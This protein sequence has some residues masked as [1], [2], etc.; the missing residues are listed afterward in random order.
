MHFLTNPY[1]DDSIAMWQKLPQ[2][3]DTGFPKIFPKIY[4]TLFDT[5]KILHLLTP[6]TKFII[7]YAV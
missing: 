2:S 6:V 5:I 4:G 3:I 7:N 1:G